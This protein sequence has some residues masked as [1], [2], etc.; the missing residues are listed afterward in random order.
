MFTG[1]TW[2]L[3]KKTFSC[4]FLEKVYACMHGVHRDGFTL[5][6]SLAEPHGVHTDCLTLG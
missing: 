1:F 4:F 6:S 3:K 2:C 5:G